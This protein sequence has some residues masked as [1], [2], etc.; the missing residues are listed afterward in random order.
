M[1]SKRQNTHSYDIFESI[2]ECVGKRD[3]AE[4]YGRFSDTEHNQ[5]LAALSSSEQ[6]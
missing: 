1:K 5:S 4:K 2:S 6:I 3:F